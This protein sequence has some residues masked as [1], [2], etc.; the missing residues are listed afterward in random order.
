MTLQP[1]GTKYKKHFKGKIKTK[2]KAGCNLE[3]GVYGLKA[4]STARIN[5][6][7]IE[8]ARMA[9]MKHIKKIGKLWIRIF[10]NIPITKK[11]VEIRMGKGKGEVN[12]WIFR[13]G[14][15]RVLFE[16]QGVTEVVARAAFRAASHKLNVES[17]FVN[18]LKTLMC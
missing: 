9:I 14:K 10:P 13:V 7:Q 12:D 5:G 15:G 16:I 11:P 3:F 2:S 17:I 4:N 6:K 18:R 1:S 8:S